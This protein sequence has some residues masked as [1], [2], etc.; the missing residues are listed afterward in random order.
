ME[1]CIDVSISEKNVAYLTIDIPGSKVN[2]INAAVMEQIDAALNELEKKGIKALVIQS[3]K[4][5][6]FIAGADLHAFKPAFKDAALGRELIERGHALHNRLASAPFP[7]I[8]AINGICL[9]GGLEMSLA[10]SYRFGSDHPKTLLGLP[11][12]NLG[13]FPGWG[14]T[15][16]APRTVGLLQGMALVLTG[17]PIDWKKAYKIGLL[18]EVAPAPFFRE[19]LEKFIDKVLAS[20][21]KSRKKKP[22]FDK[23]YIGPLFAFWKAKKDILK[24]TKG[25]YKAPLAALEVIKKGFYLPLNK[26]LALEAKTFVEGF[27]GALSQAPNL[28]QLFFNNESLKKNPGVEKGARAKEVSLLGVIGA[29][30]MGSG[31][32]WMA[33]YRQI[34]VRF[35]DVSWEMVA[36]GYEAAYKSYQT[37]IR[38]RKLRPTQANNL[39]HKI[40]GTIDYSGF[41][42]ADL[43]VEAATENK[44][45]KDKIFA[46]LEEVV[47]ADA[48][49]ATNTSSLRVTDLAAEAKHP[50]RFIG[51]HFFNPVPRMPLV[52]V[53]AGEKSLPEAVAT[54]VA[55]C[56]KLKKT[57]IVVKDCHGFL[58]NRVFVMGIAA[59]MEMVEEGVEKEQIARTL[60]AF[61]MPMDPFELADEVGN[62][63]NQKVLESFSKSY[64]DRVK[65][66]F[67]VNRLVEKGFLG[68]KTGKGFY[69]YNKKGKKTGFNEE[70]S[71]SSSKKIADQE[72]VDRLLLAMLAESARCLEEGIVDRAA[73]LDMALVLGTGFP[74]YRTGI[75]RYAEDEGIAKCVEKMRTLEKTYG[76]RYAPCRLLQ[77]HAKDGTGFY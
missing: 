9:G 2:T 71:I 54:A 6:M 21:Q 22:F 72:I 56:Q 26:A 50:E 32:S 27:E 55:F 8:A 11:E 30:T 46:E 75:L 49:I 4:E 18:D 73:H 1:E 58:V 17:K 77:D 10:C 68:K 44:E 53:V 28:I 25:H 20:K 24:K 36:K 34:P 39:F 74:P 37:L 57:P 5:E 12:V 29:G 19:E 3:G 13:I 59:T 45:L 47:S 67:V 63:V 14:G 51:M 48:L 52:E 69:L 76:P 62:D 41:F 60:L 66:S 16:R 7:T 61:G 33:S 15:Q 38:I 35:K 31:I 64:P 23:T 43:I 40:S 65:P 70:A 42:R